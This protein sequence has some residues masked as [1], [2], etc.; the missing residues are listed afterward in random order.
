MAVT[1]DPSQRA[2]IINSNQSEYG[3]SYS[4]LT[5]LAPG[6]EISA[7]Q[8][9]ADLINRIGD[10]AASICGATKLFSGKLSPGCQICSEGAWSCLFVNGCCNLNCFYCPSQQN[11][12]GL[13]GTN[14]INF[15]SS[16]DYVV[17]L[18]LLNFRGMS[19]SGG[20]PL[21]TPERTLEFLTAAKRHF[22]NRLHCWLYT[23]GSLLTTDLLSRLRDAGLDEIRFDIGAVDYLLEK[24]AMAVGII[25]TVTVEIPAVPED[26]NLLKI[27]LGEMADIG[28]NHLNLHQLRL[29]PYNYKRF[30]ERSY[31][32]LHGEKI[33]VLESELT[34]LEILLHGLDNHI[35]I[36]LNYCSFVYK[37]H[38][39]R[40]A[41]RGRGATLMGR[42]FEELTPAGYLRTL[43]L[44]G[45]PEQLN[46]VAEHLLTLKCPEDDW[47]LTPPGRSL[48]FSSRLWDFIDFTG[49]KLS[50][51]YTETPVRENLSY[52]N[53]FREIKLPS[54]QKIAIERNKLKEYELTGPA[55]QQ[56][57]EEFLS[58]GGIQSGFSE[59]IDAEIRTC[60]RLKQGLQDYF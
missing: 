3:D 22:G 32:Y 5:F 46:R 24:P 60:E 52:R 30:A 40:A 47:S 12:I 18:E 1:P 39:Q 37:H 2:R 25:P 56:F 19:L 54:G 17:Y 35:G 57:A 29:T 44:S 33:T 16:A 59:S 15:R 28:I 6:S 34:A 50:I 23:N 49:L 9:R 8:L 13:P 42:A 41:A 14:S 31:T 11:D 55:I 36:P 58:H 10:R 27:R 7:A 48:L 20:E 45:N 21:L 51:S 4:Q 26:L 43:A 38:Y 53:P